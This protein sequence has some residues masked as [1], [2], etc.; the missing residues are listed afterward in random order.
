MVWSCFSS[1]STTSAVSGFSSRS[2]KLKGRNPLVQLIAM[3]DFDKATKLIKET[4]YPRRWTVA[5]SLGG[6]VNKNK[7][8]PIHQAASKPDIPLN[9]LEL[10]INSYPE[11]LEIC[12]KRDSRIPLHLAFIAHASEDVL[13]FL[14]SKNP[15]CVM[16]Q[17]AFGRL[18]LHYAC[19][20]NAPV[21]VIEKLIGLGS[22]E[23]ITTKDNNDWTPLHVCCELSFFVETVEIML[24]KQPSAIHVRTKKGNLPISLARKNK[25]PAKDG[26]VEILE[27]VQN[28]ERNGVPFTRSRSDG[29]SAIGNN[30]SGLVSVSGGSMETT[31]LS[32]KSAVDV[33]TSPRTTTASVQ[34]LSLRPGIL[35]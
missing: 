11:S 12:D 23:A 26:I 27:E 9:F 6:S 10:L 18:P 15:N 35:A 28:C 20:N 1:D 33:A 29:G 7:I 30:E 3:G 34:D 31:S 19:S 4:S 13:M 2:S 22:P 8:L 5:P 32:S 17:D 14:M 24:E 21:K 16:V 25:S